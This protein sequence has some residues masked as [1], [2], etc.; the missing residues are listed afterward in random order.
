MNA[1]DISTPLVTITR[2]WPRPAYAQ[3]DFEMDRGNTFERLLRNN[4]ADI[5]TLLVTMT[6]KWPTPAYV[7]R[8]FD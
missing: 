5:L 3:C 1:Y 8:D 7:R 2:K 6:R 4:V